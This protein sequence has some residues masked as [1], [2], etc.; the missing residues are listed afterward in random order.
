MD[1]EIIFI[2]NEEILA[3]QLTK[4]TLNKFTPVGNLAAGT[5][6]GHASRETAA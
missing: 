3:K 5:I 1:G 6:A 4:T 2:L